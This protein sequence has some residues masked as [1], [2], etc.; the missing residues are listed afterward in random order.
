MGRREWWSEIAA[1]MDDYIERS[2]LSVV[3]QFVG[4]GIGR[5]LHEEPQVPNFVNDQF[6]KQG[7]FRIRP[8]LVIAVEPMVE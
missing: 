7:D 2:G 1:E 3:K 8:G 4:H 5:E 6:L